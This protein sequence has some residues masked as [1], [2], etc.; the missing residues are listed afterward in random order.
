MR[1]NYHVSGSIP[2]CDVVTNG[3]MRCRKMGTMMLRRR[4]GADREILHRVTGTCHLVCRKGFDLRST[5]RGVVSRIPVDRR[6]RGVITFI[7]RS[8][9][10]VM[11]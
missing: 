8:G 9:H 1:D 3:P 10:K 6:V 4:G 5:I 11:G 2:P 7:G